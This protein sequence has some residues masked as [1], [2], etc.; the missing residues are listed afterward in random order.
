VGKVALVHFSPLH[1]LLC[2]NLFSNCC[3]RTVP[4]KIEAIYTQST[5]YIVGLSR[6]MT[7]R[8]GGRTSRRDFG[9]GDAR[10]DIKFALGTNRRVSQGTTMHRFAWAMSCWFCCGVSAARYY[11]A[12]SLQLN[13]SRFLNVQLCQRVSNRFAFLTAK[14]QMTANFK[15]W[16]SR[17]PEVVSFRPSQFDS[18]GSQMPS[19]KEVTF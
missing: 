4:P 8:P 14:V 15:L 11:P 19:M 2:R 17:G 5:L 10:P 1:C 3:K 9:F 18:P 13:L 7:K 12:E 6:L 16:Y